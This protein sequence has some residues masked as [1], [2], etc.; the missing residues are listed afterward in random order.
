VNAIARLVD[1]ARC[2]AENF[3]CE[4][5]YETGWTYVLAHADRLKIGCV[6]KSETFVRN[7]IE[8]L[9][10]RLRDVQA[11]SPV[12]LALL[13]LYPGGRPCERELHQRFASHRRH[14]E[15]FSAIVLAELEFTGCP[16]CGTV[17]VPSEMAEHMRVDLERL[18]GK[19]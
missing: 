17:I 1:D 14:G 11:M 12:P 8:A 7:P 2:W 19:S 15:W 5:L 6:K 13:R 18:K 9:T 4:H 10:N 3:D 16:K